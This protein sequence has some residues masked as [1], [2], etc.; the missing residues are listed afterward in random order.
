MMSEETTVY[1]VLEVLIAITC[2]LGNAPVIWAVWSSSAL[3]EPTFCFILSLAV[4]DFL[5]GFVAVPFAVLVDGQVCTSFTVCLLISCVVIMLTMASI[6]SL[7]AIAV[8]RYLRVLIPLRYKKTVTERRSWLVVGSCWFVAFILS[9]PPIFGWN[10]QETSQSRNSTINC[11]FIKVIPMSYIVYFNFF[12]CTLTSLLVM[13][14]LYFYI[15]FAIQSNLRGRV[16]CGSTSHI[17]FK[18]ERSL[19]QSL[20]LVLVLFAFGWLPL[21]IMNCIAYFGKESD[22][23]RMGFHVGI[24]LSH[25]NSA[26]NPIVYA[27]KIPKIQEAYMRIWRNLLMCRDYNQGSQSNQTTEN[28]ISS[29]P[30][31][32]ING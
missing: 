23:P 17:Y 14:A 10:N 20:V 21:H 8:D 24:L 9:S 11:R 19:A 18:K 15:F 5:V 1:T 22:V 27:F 25:S 7:L 3:R 32:V 31:I 16:R 29:N 2:C 13:A 4:A 12:L 28:N 30:N 26:V 6:L